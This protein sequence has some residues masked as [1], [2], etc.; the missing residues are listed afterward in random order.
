[1]VALE[2]PFPPSTNHYWGARGK[3]RFITQRGISFRTAVAYAVSNANAQ[4]IDGPVALFITVDP[5]DR[6]KR[7]LDNFAGK[8]LLDALMH[9]GCFKD[10]SQVDVLVTDRG[11]LWRGGRLRVVLVPLEQ[12]D[13]VVVELKSGERIERGVMHG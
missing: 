5:P 6:R 13:R 7:D 1:M 12:V 9:A 4:K 3:R 8:A 11:Q 10:D 2:L